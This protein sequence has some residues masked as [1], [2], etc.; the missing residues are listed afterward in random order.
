MTH[1]YLACTQYHSMQ[2]LIVFPHC[3]DIV[4]TSTTV[5]QQAGMYQYNSM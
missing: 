2:W 4:N 1:A 3:V 5:T